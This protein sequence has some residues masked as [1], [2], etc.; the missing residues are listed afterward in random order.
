MVV[1]ELVAT[2]VSEAAKLVKPEVAAAVATTFG[3]PLG[4]AVVVVLFLAIQ[5]RL[6]H[7]DPKLRATPLS[8]TEMMVPFE[9]EDEL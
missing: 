8:G 9:S 3:F 7:R 1:Q 2:T 4:L 5:T 6:D